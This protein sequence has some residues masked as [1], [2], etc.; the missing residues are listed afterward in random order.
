MNAWHLCPPLKV[1]P[2]RIFVA[3]ACH[4]ACQPRQ[5][6]VYELQ[7]HAFMCK[8]NYFCLSC[9]VFDFEYSVTLAQL[10]PLSPPKRP[11]SMSFKCRHIKKETFDSGIRDF[12]QSWR[13][14]WPGRRPTRRGCPCSGH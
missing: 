8:G 14:I 13:H 11:Q 5:F 4:S 6:Y 9:T 1:F 3:N 7:L 2:G 12:P 10:I